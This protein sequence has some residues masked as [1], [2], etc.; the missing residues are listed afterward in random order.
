MINTLQFKFYKW[1]IKHVVMALRN[2]VAFV[3]RLVEIKRKYFT[4]INGLFSGLERIHS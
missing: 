4:Q 3:T 2:N 1:L